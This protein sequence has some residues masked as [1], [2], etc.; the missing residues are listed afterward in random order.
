VVHLEA[1]KLPSPDVTTADDG[2]TLVKALKAGWWVGF[3]I[4]ILVGLLVAQYSAP[5][6]IV[7]TIL[8]MFAVI[9]IRDGIKGGIQ[10]ILAAFDLA[11]RATAPLTVLCAAAGIVI[12]MVYLTG[13]GVRFSSVVLTLSQG[14]SIAALVLVALVCIILG[15]GLPVTAAYLTTVAIG[16][17]VMQELGITPYASHLFIIFFAALS[18][19]TPPFCMAAF[20]AAGIA[21]SRLWLTGWYAFKYG[22]TGYVI[23]FMFIYMPALLIVDSDPGS[24]VYAAACTC[25]GLAVLAVAVVGFLHQ[26][27]SPWERAAFA[28]AGGLILLGSLWLQAAGFISAVAA[29]LF[30]RRYNRISRIGTEAISHEEA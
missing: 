9:F 21:N 19:I 13:I 8:F 30:H 27:L 22:F 4:I 15:M 26:P 2:P 23:P 18:S 29:Y 28:V 1:G 14:N 10:K 12:S 3:P 16:G 25:A 7:V 24:I 17:P 20:T 5:R 11:V 6:A